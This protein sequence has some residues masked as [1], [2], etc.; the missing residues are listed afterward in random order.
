VRSSNGVIV[1]P[2]AAPVPRASGTRPPR[3]TAGRGSAA[4][5][6]DTSNPFTLPP[7][8]PQ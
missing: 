8:S 5:P 4:A 7:S 2:G 1:S 3:D 6:R